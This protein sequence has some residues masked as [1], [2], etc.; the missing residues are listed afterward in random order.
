MACDVT[1]MNR[2]ETVTLF[3]ERLLEVISRSGKSRSAFAARCGIDRSTLSQIL[4]D[5]TGRLPRVDTLLAIGR[6]EQVSLDW[7]LGLSADG[8]PLAADVIEQRDVEFAG[9][10]FPGDETLARWRAEALGYK[11]RHVPATLPDLVKTKAV[12]D[13]E[14]RDAAVGSPE[15][16]HAG[17]ETQLEY[18]RRPETDTEVCSSMQ[19]VESLAHGEGIW[20]SLSRRSRKKQLERMSE[21]T[22][23]L[24]PTFR[25]FLFDAR[26]RFAAPLTIFGPL[27][28]A[29]YLGERYVVLNSRE[30]VATLTRHFDGLIRAA[31]V[32]PHEVSDL[33]REMHLSA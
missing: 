4:S 5:P 20:R 10:A 3:R 9:T 28:A 25:W 26:E 21:L 32:Q 23:E 17:V 8:G 6:T 31:T 27:R 22:G 14:F 30:A 24:Y 16:R 1:I 19:S 12:F 33:F 11:V 2:S 7:L 13:Y 18:E 29:I 15:E